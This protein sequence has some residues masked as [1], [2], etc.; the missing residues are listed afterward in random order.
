MVQWKQDMRANGIQG[1][2]KP[3]ATCREIAWDNDLPDKSSTPK[4]CSWEMTPREGTFPGSSTCRSL[5]ASA[6][7]LKRQFEDGAERG[8]IRWMMKRARP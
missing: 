6:I 4:M 8:G 2:H 3:S 7:P 1:R 5:W